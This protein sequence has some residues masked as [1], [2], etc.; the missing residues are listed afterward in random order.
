MDVIT[1]TAQPRDV[2]KGGARRVRRE[3]NVPCVLYGSH[4]KP[5]VFAVP[6]PS[7]TPLIYTQETHLVRIELNSDAWECILKDLAFHPVTDRPI[8]ADFQVLQ[9]GEKLTLTVPVRY[10]GTPVG[11]TEGG[12]SSYV[13]HELEIS[14]MPQHIPSQI[15][16]DVSGVG[17]GDTLHLGN[18]KMEGIEFHAPPEQV[19]MT[20]V[21]PRTAETEEGA[22]EGLLL[23]EEDEA[24]EAEEEEE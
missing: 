4:A 19:L 18:L 12:L 13:V 20:V 16:V 10:L 11:Q 17:I 6:E 8:H 7:L 3:G 15:D 21:T 9:A 24:A 5:V 1:L 23:G 22:A 14:C 2:G